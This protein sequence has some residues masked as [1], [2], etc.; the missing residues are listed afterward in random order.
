MP[1][2]GRSFVQNVLGLP[3]GKLPPNYRYLP[4]D[5]VQPKSLSFDLAP[6]NVDVFVLDSEER[7]E[8]GDPQ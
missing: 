1:E 3:E 8:T 5:Q 4:E 2:D 6:R 7:P